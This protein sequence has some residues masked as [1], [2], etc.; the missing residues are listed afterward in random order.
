[1]IRSTGNYI[2][3]PPTFYKNATIVSICCWFDKSFIQLKVKRV[4]EY[5]L[6]MPLKKY[7]QQQQNFVLTNTKYLT[8]FYYISKSKLCQQN[9]NKMLNIF[10]MR[11]QSRQLKKGYM[12]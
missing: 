9:Q 3:L 6:P 1:M 5:Y 2:N 7:S 11:K 4:H 10:A 8:E 12:I